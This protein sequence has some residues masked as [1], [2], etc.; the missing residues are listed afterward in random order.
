MKLSSLIRTTVIAG[1]LVAMTAFGHAPSLRADI[2]GP[3]EEYRH[4]QAD[5]E[6]P[7]EEYRYRQADIEGPREEYRY[8]QADIEGSREEY[9]PGVIQG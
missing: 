8:R 6:G 2:E 7:R 5:I 4:R 9:R 1:S 3:R